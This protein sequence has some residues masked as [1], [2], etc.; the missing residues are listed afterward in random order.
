[1]YAVPVFDDSGLDAHFDD[2]RHQASGIGHGTV[3]IATSPSDDA[4][5]GIITK[6]S[7]KD[8]QI[9]IRLVSENKSTSIYALSVARYK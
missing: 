2:S 5:L 8:T 3:L 9:T 4:P 6:A 7:K 1:M